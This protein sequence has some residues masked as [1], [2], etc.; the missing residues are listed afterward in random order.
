MR[1]YGRNIDDVMDWTLPQTEV[2]LL[3]MAMM[4]EDENKRAVSMMGGS[5]GA[6]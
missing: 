3:K 6:G 4:L 2:L 1:F 5:A